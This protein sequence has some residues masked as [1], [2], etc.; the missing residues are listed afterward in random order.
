M[1][2]EFNLVQQPLISYMLKC[3]LSKSN[4][5]KITNESWGDEIEQPLLKLN[6]GAS[7]H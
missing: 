7:W 2:M 6:S 4:I 3:K 1:W 5:L